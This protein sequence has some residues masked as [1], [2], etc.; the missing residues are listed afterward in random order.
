MAPAEGRLSWS[1]HHGESSIVAK[2]VL[3]Q[4]YDIRLRVVGIGVVWHTVCRM[5]LV[6][7]TWHLPASGNKVSCTIDYILTVLY[8]E[9]CSLPGSDRQRRATRI[10]LLNQS[11]CV[12]RKRTLAAACRPCHTTARAAL[13]SA[14]D[15]HTG[16]NPGPERSTP[17]S[18]TATLHTKKRELTITMFWRKS[19]Q[20]PSEPPVTA[21]IE[22]AC[23]AH[24][25]AQ[26]DSDAPP[27]ATNTGAASK[28]P[29]KKRKKKKAKANGT[30]ARHLVSDS[31]TS[32]VGFPTGAQAEPGSPTSNE[33][34]PPLPAEVC[35]GCIVDTTHTAVPAANPAQ[36]HATRRPFSARHPPKPPPPSHQPPAHHGRRAA[37]LCRVAR[38]RRAAGGGSG[39]RPCSGPGGAQ[40]AGVPQAQGGGQEQAGRVQH[41][42]PTQWWRYAVVFGLVGKLCQLG[43]C[44][45]FRTLFRT[46][47]AHYF[48]HYLLSQPCCMYGWLI[49]VGIA[50]V[51]SFSPFRCCGIQRVW[52]V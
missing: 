18:I 37:R 44:V 49:A 50:V 36:G 41:M 10:N 9:T 48:P 39:T 11:H 3:P 52:C 13:R 25:D 47:F 6:R 32:V 5:Q 40:R 2:T 35:K 12:S 16:P 7:S 34:A 51:T 14:S 43:C 1:P 19:S 23:H 27:D 30:N 42:A 24:G 31:P 22:V 15:D 8:T 17:S 26:E 45:L 20:T 4:D 38:R 33:D 21:P 46:L 28:K 29:H